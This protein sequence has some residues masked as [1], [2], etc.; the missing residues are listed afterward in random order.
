M[1]VFRL[2]IISAKL[3]SILTTK[4]GCNIK[5]EEKENSS[6]VIMSLGFFSTQPVSSLFHMTVGCLRVW[7][8]TENLQS[9][10][11]AR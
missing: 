10:I 7:N 8:K 9:L 11:L 1:S 5:K 2:H 4:S 3:I 6:H